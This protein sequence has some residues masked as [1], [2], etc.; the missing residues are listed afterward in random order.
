[1]RKSIIFL[2]L[3]IFAQFAFGQNVRRSVIS[4]FGSKGNPVN[5]VILRSTVAQPPNAGTIKNSQN[6]L[7]QGFQQPQPLRCQNAPQA[8]F[9]IDSTR[10]GNCGWDYRFIYTED[11]EAE[12]MFSWTFSPDGIPSTSTEENP[13]DVTFGG[14]GQKEIMLVVTTENCSYDTTYTFEYIQPT[15]SVDLNIIDVDCFGNE[16][17]IIEPT[18]IGGLFPFSFNWSNGSDNT[19]LTSLPSGDYGYTIVDNDSCVVEGIVPIIE[20]DTLDGFFSS[21]GTSCGNSPDGTIDAT[22]FGGTEPYF[23]EWSNGEM[24]EDLGDL[25]IG[26]YLLE[27]TDAEG[28]AM[29]LDV[30]IESACLELDFKNLFSPNGDGSNE[31]WEI[32]NIDQYPFNNLEIYN[33]WGSLVYE[34]E[35]YDNSWTGVNIDGYVLPIGAYYYI[36]KLNDENETVHTGSVTI[37]R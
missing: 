15:F 28:C 14:S 24:T 36:M 22:I 10:S 6:N 29:F 18:V 13:L 31:I 12:T 21:T 37:L 9:L 35:S 19:V 5:G 27:V 20:P 7:R 17:G 32:T 11:S 1:M 33:R 26:N 4:S 16:T 30:L 23:F 3:A 25:P 8:A 2:I 34:Q